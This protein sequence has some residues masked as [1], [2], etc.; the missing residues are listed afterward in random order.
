M[1]IKQSY[2]SNKFHIY[3][4]EI[5]RVAFFIEKKCFSIEDYFF[6]LS[7]NSFTED[8]VA[9]WLLLVAAKRS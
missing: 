1:H 8:G 5:Y 4:C 3:N 6:E 2:Y 7:S 9:Q